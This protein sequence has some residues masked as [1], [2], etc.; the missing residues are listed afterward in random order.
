MDSSTQ[1]TGLAMP[2]FTAFGWA[3]EET[4]L[5]YALS[6]LELFIS[7][8]H[9]QLPS[10]LKDR[11]PC[12]GLSEAGQSVYLAANEDVASNTYIS[13]FARPMSL[14]LQLTFT[15]KK[16]LAKGLKQA[17]ADPA[18]WHRLVTELGP[19]WSL[20]LQQLERNEETGETTNYQD[21]FKESVAQ[22]DEDTAVDVMKKAEYLNGEEKWEV[23][24]S[25]NY[26]LPSE[27][28]AAM[29]LAILDVI[30]ERIK[31]LIPLLTFFTGRVFKKTS[32]RKGK[33]RK[34]TAV[35]AEAKASEEAPVDDSEQFTY[36]AD[37]KPLH[38]RRGFVNLLPKHWPFFAINSRT[39]TR[40]VTVYYEGIYDKNS[41]VWRLVTSDQ[42]RLVLSPIVHLWLEENFDANDQVKVVA[43]KMDDNEIQISLRQ[44]D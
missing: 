9:Q 8:L 26:R 35:A 30:M 24:L 4:A 1:F 2:V 18:R 12:Y 36:V 5:K 43:R 6:Q 28:C 37:L 21:L 10:E 34:A 44:I 14:E 20:R 7:S 22:F 38:L 39:T 42:A 27:Q 16:L 15:A 41:A 13:F 23:A 40:S 11:F 17:V 31:T 33:K 29:G 3:G 19:D 32:K 25:L